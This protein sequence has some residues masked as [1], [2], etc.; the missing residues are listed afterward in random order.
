MVGE[1]FLFSLS[2]P[3]RSI[4]HSHSP[5]VKKQPLAPSHD[6]MVESS[7]ERFADIV[8]KGLSH[9]KLTG[10]L[11]GDGGQGRTATG[12]GTAESL[13]YMPYRVQE[14]SSEGK[15]AVWFCVLSLT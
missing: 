14:V 5:K 11:V 4:V 6:R 9:D 10:M 12:S 13:K 15:H 7:E 3:G 2:L 1:Y 8:V